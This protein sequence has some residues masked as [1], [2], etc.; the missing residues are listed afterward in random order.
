MGEK[1]V[2]VKVT[3]YAERGGYNI[4]FSNYKDFASTDTSF[5]TTKETV[6]FMKKVIKSESW[7]SLTASSSWFRTL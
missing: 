6:A 4:V 2:F 5:Y 7:K 3:P 1:R